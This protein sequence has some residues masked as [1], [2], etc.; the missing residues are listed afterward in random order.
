MSQLCK[1]D[2]EIFLPRRDARVS[3][4]TSLRIFSQ[5]APLEVYPN[6]RLD[7][8]DS[9]EEHAVDLGAYSIYGTPGMLK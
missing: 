1:I 2:G 6:R 9:I 8:V 3:Q 7:A 4:L 5:L